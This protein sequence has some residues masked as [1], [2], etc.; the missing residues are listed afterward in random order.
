MTRAVALP[1]VGLGGGPLGN[2]LHPVSDAQAEAVMDTAW[3]AGV[4]YFD[5]APFYGLG[6]S[7]QRMGRALRG[8]PRSEFI[9]STKV[10]RVVRPG[11]GDNGGF[12]VPGDRHIEW[13]F[14]RDGVLRSVSESLDRLGL[15]RVDILFI[16][17]PDR[18]WPQALD[19]AYAALAE[20]R[21][22]GV[23]RW[24]GVGMN[25]SPMLVDFVKHTDLDLLLAANQVTL[26][27]RTAFAEL[28]PLC[29][30]RG[31]PVIAA[32]LFHRGVLATDRPPEDAPAEAHTYAAACVRHGV[33]LPAAALQ[34]PLRH[35]AVTTV[36]VGAH[37]PGHVTANLQSLAHPIPGALWDE[38][39]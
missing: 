13:D 34:F 31:I 38:L 16:H 6:L 7:E 12:A 32:S 27:R 17:D 30:D 25:Q 19:E 24:I 8:R 3:G 39:S 29:L 28:L 26:L 9:L 11:P 14:S 33:P 20:L 4:R 35:P 15:D 36:L 2:Y 1:R 10:G 22:Q 23:V 5:T 37:A 21:S 18:H